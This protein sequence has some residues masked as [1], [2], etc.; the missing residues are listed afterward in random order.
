MGKVVT[1]EWRKAKSAKLEFAFVSAFRDNSSFGLNILGPLCLWQCFSTYL[2]IFDNGILLASIILVKGDKLI[3]IPAVDIG[4]MRFGKGSFQLLQT[5]IH[6][7]SFQ[8]F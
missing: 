8:Y 6:I 7:F 2:D 3:R 5:E 4:I 1:R